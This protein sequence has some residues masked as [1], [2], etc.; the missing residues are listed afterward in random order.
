M[1]FFYSARAAM[2]RISVDV[3]AFDR[4]KA[5]T[6]FTVA[7]F[8]I[9]ATYFSPHIWQHGEAREALVI[10]ENGDHHRWVFPLRNNDFPAKPILYHWMGAAF[11]ELMGLSDFTIRLPSVV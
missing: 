6:F 4:V 3:L 9:L 7:A 1:A 2:D 5:G 10:R 8:L 11:S